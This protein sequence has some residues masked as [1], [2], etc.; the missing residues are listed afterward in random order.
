MATATRDEH[1]GWIRQQ[2]EVC[3]SLDSPLWGAAFDHL[4]DDT[5]AGGVTWQMLRQRPASRFGDALPLRLLGFA[6]RMA[7]TGRAPALAAVLPSCGGIADTATA[8]HEVLQLLK[9]R[10]GDF[11]AALEG[12][13]QT[14]EVGRAA[15]LVLGLL[16]SS[17]RFGHPLRL[18]EMGCSGGLNLQMDGFRYYQGESAMGPHDSPVQLGDVWDRPPRFTRLDIVDRAGCDP[19]PVDVGTD[20]G[21][22]WLRSFVWPDQTHRFSRLNGAIEL[23]RR[24]P[25]RIEQTFD[26][27]LWLAN[28]LV[29]P[30]AGRTTVVYHSIVWQ[31]IDKPARADITAVLAE[32]GRQATL[33]SPVVWLQF[34][35][36]QMNRA[37]VAVTLRAWPGD[38]Y[39][40][41]ASADFHGRWVKTAS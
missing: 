6:H 20:N 31:Y 13:P 21:A 32:A 33:E 25:P 3:R 14:N 36:D 11:L 9:D 30:A 34:E 37:Q 40:R 38:V 7:L 26:T 4:A 28:E 2:A 27:A 18:R 35:P 39:V 19:A 1:V 8:C 17:S 10:P 29:A 16:W 5:A 24:S 15:G 22:T 23:A 41:I 12:P